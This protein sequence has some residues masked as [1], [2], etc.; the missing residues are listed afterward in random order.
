MPNDFVADV[1]NVIISLIVD[2]FAEGLSKEVIDA[3][4]DVTCL[5]L[6]SPFDI[7]GEEVVGR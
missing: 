4:V 6:S 3:L 5:T 1:F 2:A 7:A